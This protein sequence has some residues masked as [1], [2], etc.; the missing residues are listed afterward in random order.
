MAGG[1]GGGA[2]RA[3]VAAGTWLSMG[4]AV[5]RQHAAQALQLSGWTD[6]AGLV[7]SLL[8]ETPDGSM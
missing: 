2:A 3:V 1:D 8:A 5:S 6:V 4:R 7:D